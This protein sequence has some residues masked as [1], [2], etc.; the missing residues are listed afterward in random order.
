MQRSRWLWMV[1]ALVS[2]MVVGCSVP[3]PTE[4]LPGTSGTSDF[5]QFQFAGSVVAG[6]GK[7]ALAQPADLSFA[8]AGQVI[9]L[10][11]EE[12]DIVEAGQVLARLDTTVMDAAL[13]HA[14]AELAVLQADL[15]KVQAGASDE[16]IREAEHLVDSAASNMSLS[17][18]QR[19]A[20]TAAAQARLDYLLALPLAE[21]LAL[22]QAEVQEAL[23][24]VEVAQ[25]ER[26]QA[27]MV[28]PIAGEVTK[29]F[30]DPYEYVKIGDAVMQ[31]GDTS[32]LNIEV[33]DLSEFD[34]A[35]IAVGDEA[36][37]MFEA[38]SAVEVPGTV[39]AIIQSDAILAAFTVIVEMAAIPEG[40]RPGMSA[41]VDIDISG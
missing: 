1:M 3:E 14:E 22:A 40:I 29:L 18:A 36:T 37:V 11:V 10:T 28:A 32:H 17:L 27:T 16:Q 26:A 33:I 23:A 41:Y 34:I 8:A 9:E 7:V 15:A 38:L 19:N 35:R 6:T 13:A 5:A 31:I 24:A 25:A 2:L 30:I 20:E 21:D 12:G 39:T 4:M